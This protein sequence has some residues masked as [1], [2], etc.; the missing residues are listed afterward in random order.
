MN[1]LT[2]YR[3]LQVPRN[4]PKRLAYAREKWRSIYDCGYALPMNG[5]RAACKLESKR[6]AQN[7][8]RMTLLQHSTVE[9]FVSPNDDPD[10]RSWLFPADV[11]DKRKRR[12]MERKH[13]RQCPTYHPDCCLCVIY[14]YAL[15][16]QSVPSHKRCDKLWQSGEESK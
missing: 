12:R 4:H 13:G 16:F 2:M 6:H 3:L 1:K 11:L 5:Y 7:V 10:E 14:A 8:T 15:E 9:R